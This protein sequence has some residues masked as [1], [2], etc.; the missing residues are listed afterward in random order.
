MT[1]PLAGA[2]DGAGKAVRLR[3]KDAASL[4]LFDRTDAGTRVLLGRRGRRH[5]FMPDTYVF[6]GGRRDRGDHALPYSTDL[7]AEVLARLA[8]D[9]DD[10]HARRRARALALAA[11]RELEE[12]TGLVLGQRGPDKRPVADLSCLRY[13][14][15]AIT[16]PGHVRRFDTRFFCTFVD[17]AGIDTSEMRETEE[18][19]DLQWVDINAISGLNIPPITQTILDDVKALMKPQPNLPF[20]IEGPY[21]FVRRGIFQRGRI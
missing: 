12:E 19:H 18:L 14:A 8:G 3:P 2:T 10:I 9:A 5:V 1:T 7:R 6:P 13:V 11:V 20:D 4:I 16:P 15:R 17:E 21:Y